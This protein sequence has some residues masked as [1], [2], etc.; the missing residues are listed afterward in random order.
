[1]MPGKTVTTSAT[2]TTFNQY[3]GAGNGGTNYVQYANTDATGSPIGDWSS[4]ITG[5][6]HPNKYRGAAQGY[7][8]DYDIEVINT[9]TGDKAGSVVNRSYY[10]SAQFATTNTGNVT[11]TLTDCSINTNF[12]GGGFLGGVSGNVISTLTDCTVKGSVFG[13]GYSA[14][15]GTVTIYNKDKIPPVV[16]TYTGM[17]KPQSGGTSTTYNWTHERGTTSSPITTDGGINY[18]YTEIHLDNLGA[19]NGNVTLTLGGT[20]RVGTLL[21]E[22]GENETLKEG[23]GNVYGGGDESG[24]L[25]ID[26]NTPAQVTVILRQGTTVFG[27]VYGGGNR[28]AVSGNSSVI[29]QDP[30]P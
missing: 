19:V 1:M 10:Y 12:Y 24:V 29:I 21:D 26:N 28:G 5:N 15:A 4:T 3:F 8:A 18:F 2:G 30:Q 20:T 9:S 22:G 7:E 11:S 6:Y 23:T 25:Q 16:N 14:S 13:A 17:I 27:N